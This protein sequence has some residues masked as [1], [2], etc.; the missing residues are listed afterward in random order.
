MDD[1]SLFDKHFW[2]ELWKNC[3]TALNRIFDVEI[4]K[5]LVLNKK[6]SLI[7]ESLIL[8]FF[9][10][11][12]CVF[13]KLFNTCSLSVEREQVKPAI[14]TWMHEKPSVRILIVNILHMWHMKNKIRKTSVFML[15]NF[16]KKSNKNTNP[17]YVN[18]KLVY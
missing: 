15:L 10:V 9:F 5:V 11:D 8:R 7:F 16:G 17:S 13:S 1:S 3:K 12:F 14:I 18:R 2:K 6:I 4:S